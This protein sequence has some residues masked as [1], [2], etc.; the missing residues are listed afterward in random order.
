MKIRKTW[1]LIFYTFALAAILWYPVNK[2]IKF[3]YPSVAPEEI[4]FKTA[5]NDPY[6]PMR[7]RY[8][9]LRVR[10]DRVNTSD[11][12]SRFKYRDKGYAVIAKDKNGFARILRLEKTAAGIKKGELAVKVSQIWYFS[13]W[14]KKTAYYTFQW[15]FDRFYLNEL[16]APELEAELQSRKTPFALKVRIWPDG[17]CA[18][19]G[20]LKR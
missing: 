4:K 14:K 18:V 13:S 8:V 1:L 9:R 11:K 19:S 20:L 2:I 15:P 3:E 12:K 5:V 10:P 16:K 7:G 6:D 17:D